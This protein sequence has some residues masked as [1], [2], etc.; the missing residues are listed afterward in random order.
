MYAQTIVLSL[1][2]L[3]ALLIIP[4]GDAYGQQFA[5]TWELA[6]LGQSNSASLSA[7]S[8]LVEL[9]HLPFPTLQQ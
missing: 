8:P 2:V 9:T 3:M 4:V 6:V 1:V 5:S 7:T